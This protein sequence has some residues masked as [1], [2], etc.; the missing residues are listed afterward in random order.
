MVAWVLDAIRELRFLTT[1][2]SSGCPWG[3]LVILLLLIG[4]CCCCCGFALGSLAFSQHCRKLALQILQVL[5]NHWAPAG[6]LI[7]DHRG[8]LAEYRRHQ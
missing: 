7:V 8:R 2:P 3:L 4:T 1:T 5:F 6:G